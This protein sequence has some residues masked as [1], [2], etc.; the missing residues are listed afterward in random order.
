[1]R[2]NVA[3]FLTHASSVLMTLFTFGIHFWLEERNL[4]AG[5]VFASLALF[6]QLAVPLFIFPAI[7]P[8]IINAMVRN[9]AWVVT[10]LGA[11]P[12]PR[13]GIVP[14]VSPC[15]RSPRRDWRSFF[16]FRRSRIF[17]RNRLPIGNRT[18]TRRRRKVR[19]S[20]ATCVKN[21][22]FK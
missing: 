10:S 20:A 12:P 17:C 7:V 9:N 11:R 19:T 4:D 15:C 3:D 5:N 14:E 2:F 8:I 16:G 13:N 21:P 6:S 22:I 18:W 1:M